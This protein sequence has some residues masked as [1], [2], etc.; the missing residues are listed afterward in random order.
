MALKVGQDQNGIVVLHVLSHEIFLD[1]LSFRNGEF[2]I[3]AFCIHEIHAEIFFP[4]MGLQGAHMFG[5][6]ISLPF[7]SSITFYHI[8]S[9]H[10]DDGLPEGGL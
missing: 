2:Q 3:R 7:V 9:Y 4:A 1:H 5:C 6:G 8:A 10:I